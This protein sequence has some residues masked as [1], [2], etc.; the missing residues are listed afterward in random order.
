MPDLPVEPSP[1]GPEE[2]TLVPPPVSTVRKRLKPGERRAQILQGLAA[3]LE[4]PG[5]ERIT[6]SAL[7]AQLAV[8]EAVLYR[9][10]NNKAQMYE[11][12]IEFI[13]SSIFGLVNRVTE[14]E[15]SGLAQTRR[16]IWLLLQFA[17]KNP[18]LTR[19][20]VGDVLALESDKLTTRMNL[21]FDK[22]EAQ[23]RQSLRVAAAESHEQQPTVY[24]PVLDPSAQASILLAFV[25]GRLQRFVRSDFRRSPVEHLDMALNLLA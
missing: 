20:M 11:G 24:H 1:E 7:A 9:H 10:F 16:I 4:Q 18:G 23:L 22:I 14:R 6:T 5:M 8:S 25:L 13:E 17:E 3:M 19:V 2:F 12:L 21:F 15:S